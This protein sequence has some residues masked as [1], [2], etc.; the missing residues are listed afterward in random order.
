MVFQCGDCK[1]WLC[2]NI[3]DGGESGKCP[4]VAGGYAYKN[5]T[6]CKKFEPSVAFFSELYDLMKKAEEICGGN[7]YEN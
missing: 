1:Y 3:W 6:I 5:G 7:D 2:N 4:F